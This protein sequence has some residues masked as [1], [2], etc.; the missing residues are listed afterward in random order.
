[1]LR[2][3]GWAVGAPVIP[4]PWAVATREPPALWP[5]SL[6]T[7]ASALG[8]PSRLLAVAVAV[9][10]AAAAAE[11]GAGVRRTVTTLMLA[12][13]RRLLHPEHLGRAL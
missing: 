11:V 8:N 10:A 3:T 13:Q 1:M 12:L 7:R 5:P 2:A 6:R 4:P 9:V